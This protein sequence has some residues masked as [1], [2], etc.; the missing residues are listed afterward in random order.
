MRKILEGES[1]KI[2]TSFKSLP[3]QV[4]LV[5]GIN[6]FND[7][8]KA[9]K[10]SYWPTKKGLWNFNYVIFESSAP[11][12]DLYCYQMTASSINSGNYNSIF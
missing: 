9:G 5:K 1:P 11:N 6:L 10:T 8:I 12:K 3:Y 7:I 4:E 2:G